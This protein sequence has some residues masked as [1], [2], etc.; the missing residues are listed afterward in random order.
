MCTFLRDLYSLLASDIVSILIASGVEPALKK[1]LHNA[2]YFLKFLK[3]QLRTEYEST[4]IW[5]IAAMY[6]NDIEGGK[7][8]FFNEC[9]FDVLLM[10]C[11]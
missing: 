8:Y 5:R 4:N 10:R 1:N 6:S 7:R 3:Q 9:E 2:R 11:Y